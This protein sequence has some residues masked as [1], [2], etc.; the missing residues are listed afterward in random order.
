MTGLKLYQG[1]ATKIDKTDEVRKS[2]MT[3]MRKLARLF[4]PICCAEKTFSSF[5]QLYDMLP[6]KLMQSLAT[7]Q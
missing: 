4:F 7:R 6:Q 2:I 1:V 5:R 3:N